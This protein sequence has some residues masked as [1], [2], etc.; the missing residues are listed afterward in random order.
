MN[1]L[2]SL[3]MIVKD[4]EKTL[5]RCL[6]SVKGLV[7]E[8]IVVDTGSTDKTVEIAS[9]FTNHVYPFQWINDFAAAKNEAIRKSTA[10]WIL[11]LDADE[12]VQSDE[13]QRLR[14]HLQ[15]LNYAEPQGIILPIFNFLGH[16]KDRKFIESTA[17]RLF[18]NHP[19]VYF[20]RPIH[21]QITYRHGEIKLTNH[22]FKI[23]HTGYTDETRGRKDK[24]TR[25]LSIFESLSTKTDYDFFTLGNEYMILKDYKKALYYYE[26]A[27]KKAKKDEA[28][29]LHC[30]N[31]TINAYFHLDRYK[32]A[33]EL[34]EESIRTWPYYSDYYCY[35]GLVFSHF[36]L[37]E[38]AIHSFNKAL[39]LGE[40][41]VSKNQRFWLISP[42][43]GSS[44]PYSKLSNIYM[45]LR[46]M[47]KAVYCLTKL[48]QLIPNDRLVLYQLLMILISTDSASSIIEFLNKKYPEMTA[49]NALLLFQMGLLTGNK[50]IADHYYR[51][52]MNLNL[53]ISSINNIHYA[54]IS[55]DRTLFDLHLSN[56]N[57]ANEQEETDLAKTLLL[58]ASIWKD[59]SYLNRIPYNEETNLTKVTMKY[60][61]SESLNDGAE[62]D[63]LMIIK[64]LIDLFK[65]G[66]FEVY[67]WLI[68]QLPSH[69]D[70][71]ANLLGD[72]FYTQNQIDL[73]FDYYSM[74]LQRNA[75]QATG[76]EN[77]AR[78][79][80]QQGEITEGLNFLKTALK[81]NPTNIVSYTL[82]LQYSS[83]TQEKAQF[84]ELMYNQFPQYRGLPFIKSL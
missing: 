1:K 41:P 67:D 66:H 55:N 3:C 4:E 40:N 47:P 25:N 78:L 65:M 42:T 22:Y 23:F 10:K 53:E 76:Y 30:V 8:I 83:D 39:E 11:V 61:L 35:R 14:E 31:S 44:L 72:Y 46:D 60:I 84:K 24:S 5:R 59:T 6:D 71:I 18:T 45:L 80:L 7:D 21:E 13:H 69:Q 81:I 82:F 36:G 12:Y 75:L 56:L 2:L 48:M 38:Q 15:N 49:A 58:A 64:L 32:E 19:D 62:I 68:K 26:R 43:Y 50:E 70:S 16:V 17:V 54:L 29:Y 74:L 73:A 28:W 34:I 52:C 33:S 79:Y 51:A 27:Y 57:H 20:Y 37:Y 77:I 63:L 9:E